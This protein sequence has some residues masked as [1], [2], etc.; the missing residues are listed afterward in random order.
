MPPHSHSSFQVSVGVCFQYDK[1]KDMH[2]F[3]YWPKELYPGQIRIQHV[4]AKEATGPCW[5]RHMAQK[6]YKGEDYYLSIDSHSRFVKYWDEALISLLQCC[7]SPKPIIT[8]YPHDY[9]LP[10]NLTPET[11][12]ILTC[13]KEF[14]EDGM[15][16]ITGKL[17]NKPFSNPIP[18]LFWVSGFSFSKATVIDE[19]PYDP[20]LPFLFFGEESSMTV[21]LWTKGWDFFA[22]GK[23]IIYHLWSRNYRPNF[24]ENRD[25]TGKEER[26]RRRVKYMLGMIDSVESEALVEFDK[27]ALPEW[28]QR[29]ASSAPA[30]DHDKKL[31]TLMAY[32][33]FSGVDF[34]NKTITERARWGGL[35]KSYFLESTIDTLY[36][37]AKQ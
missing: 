36:Q 5:A 18:T 16:R 35:D 26:S 31:R 14:G 10:N 4:S 19:V 3:E 25:T 6:L 21:R 30:L 15:L 29:C 8:T 13:A 20:H 7:P 27:Y 22:P 9:E 2:C 17:L 33:Q 24:R 28:S 23:V 37:L 34:R 11:K 1:D 12:P 32:Q